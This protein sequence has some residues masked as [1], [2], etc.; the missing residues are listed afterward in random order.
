[1]FVLHIPGCQVHV[2]A[3]HLERG[4]AE[5]L[6]QAEDIPAVD[7]VAH[8]EGVPAEVRVEITDSCISF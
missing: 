4:M 5:D 2:L 6:L 3:G 8:A 1:M 7:Q